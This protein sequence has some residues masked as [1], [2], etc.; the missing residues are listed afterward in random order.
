MT[1]IAEGYLRGLEFTEIKRPTNVI[2]IQETRE[3]SKETM[4]PQGDSESGSCVIL[5]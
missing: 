1:R 2:S 4:E 3:C 5:A